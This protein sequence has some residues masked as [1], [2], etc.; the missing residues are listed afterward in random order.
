MIKIE[1]L[2]AQGYHFQIFYV[3]DTL[4]VSKF[5]NRDSW[6]LISARYFAKE[7]ESQKDCERIISSCKNEIIGTFHN[8][9][10]KNADLY[11]HFTM[12]DNFSQTAVSVNNENG[13]EKIN[14]IEV[15]YDL[16]LNEVE[17]PK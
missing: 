17:D 11:Q 12:K 15:F 1:S 2:E 8:I 9:I 7:H 6:Y 4:D 3:D 16:T 10:R 14:F 13:I 5:R